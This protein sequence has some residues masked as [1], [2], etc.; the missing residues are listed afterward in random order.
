MPS[1]CISESLY[2]HSRMDPV[3]SWFGPRVGQ[4]LISEMFLV[5]ADIKA[6]DWG[7]LLTEPFPKLEFTLIPLQTSYVYIVIFKLFTHKTLGKNTNW[8]DS[9]PNWLGA[10]GL[11]RSI[12]IA[13]LRMLAL[14]LK[15]RIIALQDRAGSSG[16][17]PVFLPQTGNCFHCHFPIFFSGSV[18]CTSKATCRT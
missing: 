1:W 7:H 16:I 14:C 12:R 2:P 6:K 10:T 4:G 3:A 15:V 11:K 9:K 17:W 18:F 5:F 8:V 13:W